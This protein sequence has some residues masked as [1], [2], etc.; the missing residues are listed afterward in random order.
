VTAVDPDD[1]TIRRYVVWHYRY[2]PA[3]HERRQVVVSAFD[4]EAEWDACMDATET[5]LGARRD[6]GQAVDLREHV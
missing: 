6:A 4:T 1:D 2:D 5:A 3:R